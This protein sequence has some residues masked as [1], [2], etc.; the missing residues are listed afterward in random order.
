MRRVR[1]LTRMGVTLVL[2][3]IFLASALLSGI[4][5][6]NA[7]PSQPTTPT[8]LVTT[9]ATLGVPEDPLGTQS[10]RQT[11]EIFIGVDVRDGHLIVRVVDDW[12]PG[13]VP[14][15]MRSWTGAGNSPSGAGNWQ[16]NQ[17]LDVLPIYD[18]VGTFNGF[19]VL[20][21]DG[22]RYGY[23]FLQMKGTAPNV[24]YVYEKK[25]GTYA[26]L[27]APVTCLYVF[28]ERTNFWDCSLPSVTW[29]GAYTC[30]LYTSPSP[31]DLSTSRMPS[32]A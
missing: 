24:T 28:G 14:L 7:A 11:P 23:T 29:T 10:E 1:H 3:P 27:E 16:F 25:V 20:E 22:N 32:S 19:Q 4:P 18:S 13:R 12:G 30:L 5:S 26:T 31:R 15:L 6:A 2:M 8:P 9:T 17:M 21:S